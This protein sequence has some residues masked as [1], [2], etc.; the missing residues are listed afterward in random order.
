[1]QM[2]LMI[3]IPI[4]TTIGTERDLLL[5]LLVLSVG[6]AEL[7]AE[8]I[9]VGCGK[10]REEGKRGIRMRGRNRLS[11]VAKEDSALLR[12]LLSNATL[13][14]ETGAQRQE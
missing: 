4:M 7:P 12:T 14:E 1:M 5:L 9:R 8:G 3:E 11:I 6:V 13:S 10:G 2:K